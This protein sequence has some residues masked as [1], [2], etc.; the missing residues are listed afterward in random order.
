[1]KVLILQFS[2]FLD[3][4]SPCV[5]DAHPGVVDA[6]PRSEMKCE[7][8]C[9]HVRMKAELHVKLRGYLFDKENQKSQFVNKMPISTEEAAC[10]KRNKLLWLFIYQIGRENHESR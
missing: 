2:H 10:I 5:V 4:V 3:F 7:N 8:Y 9:I 1:M 6:H